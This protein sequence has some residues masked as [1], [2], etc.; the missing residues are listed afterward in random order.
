VA[1]VWS[2]HAALLFLCFS[3]FSITEW[4]HC[5]FHF[6]LKTSLHNDVLADDPKVPIMMQGVRFESNPRLP[7]AE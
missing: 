2:G 4:H 1:K 7:K 6:K 3:H 5:S